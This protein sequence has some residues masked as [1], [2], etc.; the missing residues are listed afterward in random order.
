[1]EIIPVGSKLGEINAKQSA[2]KRDE[3]TFAQLNQVL[4]ARKESNFFNEALLDNKKNS[5]C[6]DLALFARMG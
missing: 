5:L 3:S 2:L 1:M 6:L 4:F